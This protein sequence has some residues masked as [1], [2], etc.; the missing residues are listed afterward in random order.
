MPLT[1]W[2]GASFTLLVVCPSCSFP[3]LAEAEIMPLVVMSRNED[4]HATEKRRAAQGTSPAHGLM[5][6]LAFFA[7]SISVGRSDSDYTQF[8]KICRRGVRL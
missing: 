3:D 5:I 8:V 7:I 4:V 1:L 6:C 2:R